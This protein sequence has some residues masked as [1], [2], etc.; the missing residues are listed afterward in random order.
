MVSD[1]KSVQKQESVPEQRQK[2]NRELAIELATETAINTAYI[3]MKKYQTGKYTIVNEVFRDREQLDPGT[4]IVP[5]AVTLNFK[6]EGKPEV[7]PWIFKL[8]LDNW[9]GGRFSSPSRGASFEKNTTRILREDINIFLVPYVVDSGKDAIGLSYMGSIEDLRKGKEQTLG[10]KTQE[11]NEKYAVRGGHLI[12][13]EGANY[14]YYKNEMKKML[15]PIFYELLRFHD[16]CKNSERLNEHLTK[17]LGNERVNYKKKALRNY[18]RVFIRKEDFN[19]ISRSDTDALEKHLK[20]LLKKPKEGERLFLSMFYPI[21]EA[22][23][24]EP[25]SFTHNNFV[26]RHIFPNV[27]DEEGNIRIGV[28]DFGNSKRDV[29]QRDH[30]AF[31]STPDILWHLQ[32]SVNLLDECLFRYGTKSEELR[33]NFS[34]LYLYGTLFNSFGK[35]EW[36]HREFIYPEEHELYCK[37]YPIYT[38]RSAQINRMDQSL[39]ILLENRGYFK[40]SPKDI[41]SFKRL[42]GDFIPFLYDFK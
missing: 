30:V 12:N 40:I 23:E 29:I 8:L 36:K 31:S 7:K 2:T 9:K 32:E 38:N 20:K 15:K 3:L 14:G 22:Y 34:K 5:C 19:G 13:L 4:R 41:E 42:K 17:Y 1:I 24:N 33:A 26:P 18:R 10:L 11:L 35:S 6:G 16:A 27:K 28:I 25:R 37:A 39:E 21:I